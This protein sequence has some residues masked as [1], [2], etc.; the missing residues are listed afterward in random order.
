MPWPCLPWSSHLPRQQ[1]LTSLPSILCPNGCLS[2][3]SEMPIQ[4]GCSRH[5]SWVKSKPVNI[6]PKAL[7]DL[8][9][10]AWNPSRQTPLVAPWR[11]TFL[12]LQVLEELVS[13]WNVLLSLVYFLESRL[14]HCPGEVF[15]SLPLRL[16]GAPPSAFSMSPTILRIV[17]TYLSFLRKAMACVWLVYYQCLIIIVVNRKTISRTSN[18]FHI[19]DSVVIFFFKI[20]RIMWI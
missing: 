20:T 1:L 10:P 14:K 16:L 13:L 3:F 5:N 11:S 19:P 9:L 7:Q 17:N 6:T 18:C 15:L 8:S 12:H 4:P 2:G